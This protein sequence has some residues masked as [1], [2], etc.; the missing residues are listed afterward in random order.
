M[1]PCLHGI[2]GV[3]FETGNA[4]H[5]AYQVVKSVFKRHI[6]MSRYESIISALT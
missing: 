4:Y 1:Y 3:Q 2:K 6:Q 5:K